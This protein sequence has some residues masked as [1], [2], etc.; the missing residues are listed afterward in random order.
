MTASQVPTIDKLGG[1]ALDTQLPYASATKRGALLTATDAEVRSATTTRAVVAQSMGHLRHWSMTDAQRLAL[2]A[3][4]L[5]SRPLLVYAEDTDTR[6]RWTGSAWLQLDTPWTACTAAK[7]SVV[8]TPGAGTRPLSVRKVGGV[9][10]LE[11]GFTVNWKSTASDEHLVNLPAGFA[12]P[13]TLQTTATDAWN[14][15]G[16]R[17]DTSGH[18]ILGGKLTTTNTSIP[19]YLSAS[20]PS[21]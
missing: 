14:V 11:G 9:V 8:M 5:G 16:A 6:W 1:T 17:I 2:T 7:T 10:Y 3:A 21:N 12:P 4:E 18:V 20:W 13:Y 15:V 19:V